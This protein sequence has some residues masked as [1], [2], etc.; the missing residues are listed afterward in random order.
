M[1]CFLFAF[2]NYYENIPE[3]WVILPLGNV[4]KVFSGQ[5]INVKSNQNGL[6]PI[7][8]GNGIVGY[9][10]EY[11]VEP[12]TIIIGRV[13]ANCGCVHYTR[14]K[15]FITDNALIVDKFTN[16]IIDEYL[17]LVLES[18]NLRKLSSSTAQPLI[19]GKTIYPL[20][21]GIPSIRLQEKIILKYNKIKNII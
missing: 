1:K 5:C 8:G 9:C 14:S 4:L 3:K 11:I 15:S 19:S 17:I 10:N 7:Y 12:N 21:I 13:G 20:A 6:Y 16:C 2:I 18:K